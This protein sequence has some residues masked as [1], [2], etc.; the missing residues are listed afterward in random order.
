[1]SCITL[2]ELIDRLDDLRNDTPGDA[3]VRFAYQ[4]S[5]PLMSD[6]SSVDVCDG[7]V[8]LTG[9]NEAYMPGEVRE[10]LGW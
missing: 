3:V 8:Y 5:Y 1:M 7:V 6:L 10:I 2:N 9:S 4:P